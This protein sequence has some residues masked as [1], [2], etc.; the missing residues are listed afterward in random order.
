MP[1]ER[2]EPRALDRDLAPIASLIGDPTRVAILAA[3]TEQRLLPAGELARRA[4]VHPATATAH[5]RRL[6]EGGLVIVHVQGRHRYHQLAGPQVA[7]VIEAL[8]QL[9]PAKPVRSLRTDRAAKALAEAR[10]CYDHLAGRRGVEL[11]ERLLAAGALR[12]VG[13]R[14]HL[15]TP[16]GRQRLSELGIDPTS[17][18]K[19]RRVLAR[20]CVDWTQR[21]PHLAGALPAALTSRLIQLGWLAPTAG[22]GLRVAPDYTQRL[23]AWLAGSERSINSR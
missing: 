18:D 17:L 6:V 8:A 14:D 3:L 12:T 1:K 5:L 7:A 4:G 22:R 23:D 19:T 13:A 11:R 2:D 20:V 16:V 21:Q 9:A 15:L 10:T